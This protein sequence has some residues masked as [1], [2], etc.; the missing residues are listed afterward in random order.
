MQRAWQ[1]CFVI[2]E[3]SLLQTISISLRIL[4]NWE[5]GIEHELPLPIQKYIDSGQIELIGRKIPSG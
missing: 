4:A 5:G 2:M 3:L 1:A